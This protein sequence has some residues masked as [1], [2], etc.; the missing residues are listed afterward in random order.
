MFGLDCEEEV[1]GLPL[2]AWIVTFLAR[3]VPK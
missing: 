2:K 1:V 3:V